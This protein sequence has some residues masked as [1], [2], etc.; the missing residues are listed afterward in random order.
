MPSIVVGILANTAG[1]LSFH[2][3]PRRLENIMSKPIKEIR[4]SFEDEAAQ[5]SAKDLTVL[6]VIKGKSFEDVLVA[7]MGEYIKKHGKRLDEGTWLS[8]TE[9][10]ERL[11]S[12]Y[13]ITTNPQTLSNRR[14]RGDFDGIY[15][16]DGK[17]KVYYLLERVAEKLQEPRRRTNP[18]KVAAA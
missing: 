18:E 4:V 11:K 15:C 17:V 3:R 8:Q 7:A 5:K 9:L 6:A 1:R 14:I 12:D 13:D 2:R 10:I 16:S